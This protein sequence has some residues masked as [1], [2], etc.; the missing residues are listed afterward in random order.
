MFVTTLRKESI[1]DHTSMSGNTEEKKRNF[2]CTEEASIHL[3]LDVP[4]KNELNFLSRGS[5]LD[6]LSTNNFNGSVDSFN[7]SI[8]ELSG[9]SSLSNAAEGNV[10][11]TQSE[12]KPLSFE[13]LHSSV[14]QQESPK[15]VAQASTRV[16][17]GEDSVSDYQELKFED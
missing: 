10:P 9:L 12:T 17:I 3:P 6:C 2:K 4:P 13:H 8:D 5:T 14:K 7:G 16:C 1:F 11:E 15:L